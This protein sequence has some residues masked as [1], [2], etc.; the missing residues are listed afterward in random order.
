MQQVH[1]KSLKVRGL[2]LLLTCE[3]AEKP[4]PPRA[5]SKR[6]LKTK[7]ADEVGSLLCDVEAA[8]MSRAPLLSVR[9]FVEWWTG[10]KVETCWSTLHH[11][12]RL[13]AGVADRDP[14]RLAVLEESLSHAAQL[15]QNDPVRLRLEHLASTFDQS[16]S[17]S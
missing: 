12:E 15:D 9:R 5:G 8:T 1:A 7:V 4:A 14:L 13:L 10:T 6:D 16:K 17:G 11:A 3:L 2:L